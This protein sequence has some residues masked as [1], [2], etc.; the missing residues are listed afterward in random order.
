MAQFETDDYATRLAHAKALE[1][2]G[3]DPY[4]AASY[5]VSHTFAQLH[6]SY[7]DLRGSKVTVAGRL[8]SK[9]VHGGIMFGH[10]SDHTRGMQT[11]VEKKEV[12]EQFPLIVANYDRGD[13]VGIQGILD[14]TK[15]GD[16][17]VMARN[18]TMLA[19]S[20]RPSPLELTD[21]E[22]KQRQRY[23][24]LIVNPEARERM[25]VRSQIAQHI[26]ETFLN[27]GCVEVETPVLDTTYGG[28]QAKPF[29]T[30]HNALNTDV[31]LR[32]SN[33]LY[34]KRLTLGFPQGVF[35]VSRDFRNEGMD[36]THNPEFTQVEMYKPFWDYKDMMNMTEQMFESMALKIKGTTVI[37]YPIE[38]KDGKEELVEIDYKAPWKRVTVYDGLRDKLG[39]NP[40]QIS[41]DE[42]RSVAHSHGVD[43]YTRDDMLL[44][45]FEEVYDADL[46]Q[47]TFVYDYPADTSALTKKHRTEPG[48]VERFEFY[49][50]N[51]ELGNC[52]TELNDPR[53]QRK[54]F[55]LEQQKRTEGKDD[56]AMQTDE[57]F[58]LAQEYGMPLQAGIGISYDRPTMLFTGAKHIREV[59]A[60]PTLRRIPRS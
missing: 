37:P 7:D 29:V 35:E 25:M 51:H 23:L 43:A 39:I 31:F 45:L 36:R 58:I 54:R 1:K 4:P 28:A 47:P 57:D 5:P 44:K 52:Y 16:I 48:L 34:L 42:L 8:V 15:R 11:V 56:E 22:I 38:G 9:R 13:W 10:V 18:V 59:I 17:S 49:A 60:F 41:D 26:R 32:I 53:E 55:E 50:G 20:L 12:P 2:A 21:P 14:Q 27:L 40:T 33:E 6:E 24:D 46:V 19:K 30:H 3:I